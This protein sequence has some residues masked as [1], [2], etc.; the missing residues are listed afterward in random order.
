MY[1]L[2]TAGLAGLMLIA[3]PLAAPCAETTSVSME[4]IEVAPD[5][6]TFQEAQSKRPF[7]P[8]GTNYTP[9]WS[10]WAPDYFGDD[11][12]DAEQIERDFEKMRELG[13]N[14]CKIVLPCRRI[15]P[16][17]QFPHDVRLSTTTLERFDRTLE[18]AGRK[19][20]RLLLTVE[21]GW[22]GWPEWFDREGRWYGEGSRQILASLWKEL[23]TR[24]RG[25]GRIF[26]YSFCV[27]TELD[28]WHTTASL[29]AWRDWAR[30]QYGTVEAANRAWKTEFADWDSVGV[31]IQDGVNAKFWQLYPEG[32]D[33]NENR[34][35][36]PFL[37]DYIV[38]REFTATR[39]MYDHARAVKEVDPK[40]LCTMGFVQWNPLLR[41]YGERTNDSPLR[42]PEYNAR[43]LA[44]VLDFI[45]IHFYPIYPDAGDSDETQL[46][47]LEL[48][49]RWAHAGK[50]VILEEFNG[51]P[52][53]EPWLGKVA[54]YADWLKSGRKP[55][56]L[57][58]LARERSARNLEWCPKAIR[59]TQDCVSGWLVWTFQNVPDSDD[60]TKVCGLLDEKGAITPWGHKFRE[61]AAAASGWKL[62]RR[63]AERTIDVDKRFLYTSG[64]YQELLDSLLAADTQTV[65]FNVESNAS[66][67]RLL[68]EPVPAGADN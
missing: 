40:A 34:T 41:Q 50:P 68:K 61:I 43:E 28:A 53:S 9:A 46:R 57:D 65:D 23:A 7:V 64:R 15:I 4:R 21:A 12:Y 51:Q 24:Y 66:V 22:L 16:G 42:G 37:Y 3:S 62:T 44:R 8:F 29:T 30:E 32:T 35:N 54:L 25:D 20:I 13:V 60:V 26:A 11:T 63:P 36:D 38:F 58:K 48:W 56:L 18:L 1:K 55:K 47:Y 6:W 45:S 39:F 10:G 67:D 19:G 33:E 2:F 17:S 14:V 31:P 27:E 5:N 52:P 59:R 49:A